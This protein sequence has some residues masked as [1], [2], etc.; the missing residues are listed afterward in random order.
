MEN[1][2]LNNG[3]EMPLV[4][5]GVFRVPDG[6]DL[7]E[8]VKTAIAK[9]Y[10]SIDTAQV[11][12]NE[13]S[14]GRGI[15]AAIDE[16]LVA[17]EEL[18]VTSKVWND[19]LSYEETLAAYASS[20]EKLGLDYLDLYLIHWPGLD[21][22]YI[23]AYKALEKIYQDGRVRSIGVSN[24]HVHHLEQLLKETTVIPVINQI[25]FHPH[26]TQEEV[27]NYCKEHRI[28]VEAWSPLMNGSLLEEAL[29]QQLASKYNKTP[30]Q[31]VLRYDVQHG[32]V[33]IP[34][35]MTPS[36][37][38]EN[39]D[40]FDFALADEEMAQLDAMNDGLRCGPDPEKFNF[41]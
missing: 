14:V 16:G 20:L 8:A 39:L 12:R 27:R 4:G 37:M 18:F 41:K 10:R 38:T 26:L 17:R 5:Y 22:N 32:V 34:K 25:E 3:L 40:V 29:I 33:T 28:Q 30:A 7:A 21:T 11:Y 6:D 2:T 24:F 15:R 23:E 1:V 35:T 19:G 36:R 9:G 31:I 13:E